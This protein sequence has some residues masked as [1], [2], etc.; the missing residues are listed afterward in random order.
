MQK[1]DFEKRNLELRPS[2]TRSQLPWVG[3]I[4]S[5]SREPLQ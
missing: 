2:G 1:S 4:G 5:L 3:S